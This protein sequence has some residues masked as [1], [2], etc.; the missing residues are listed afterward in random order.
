MKPLAAL[1][2]LFCGSILLRLSGDA[3]LHHG[4]RAGALFA[5]SNWI[6]ASGA[7]ALVIGA[8]DTQIQF[9]GWVA[10]TIG[11]AVRML[12]DRRR[13]RGTRNDRR[14]ASGAN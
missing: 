6:V 9:A 7:M 11:T 3:I 4:I 13:V 8:L 10:V 2:G 14:A 1:I 5:A 12:A